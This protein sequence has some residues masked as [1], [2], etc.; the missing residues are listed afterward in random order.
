MSVRYLTVPEFALRVSLSEGRVRQLLAKG[1]ISGAVKGRRGWLIPE[2]ARILPPGNHELPRKVLTNEVIHMERAGRVFTVFNHA[3]GVGKTTL[4]R[5]LGYGL[6]R[7]GLRVLLIDVDPQANL[8]QWLGI[9]DPPKPRTLWSL[10]SNRGLPQPYEVFGL[11]LVPSSLDVATLDVELRRIPA[12]E[13]L[14]RNAL[15]SLAPDYDVVLVD[16][17]PSLGPLSFLAGLAGEGFIVPLEPSAKGVAGLEAL[18]NTAELYAQVVGASNNFIRYF[19]PNRYDARVKAERR[20]TE[21]L[22]RLEQIAPVGPTLAN[23]PAPHRKAM[24]KRVP[25]AAADPRSQAAR[26]IEALVQD[27]ST[28]VLALEVSP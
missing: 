4:T 22:G 16:S 2:D 15:K 6:A 1:R 9:E 8:S 10:V 20:A 12:G 14:L 28:R 25:V 23:R 17:P 7:R 13:I 11:S 24:E 19:V 27:F 5:D 26:E 3:G 21:M 18:I